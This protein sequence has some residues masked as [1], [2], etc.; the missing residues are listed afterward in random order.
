[1]SVGGAVEEYKIVCEFM[2]DRAN[3]LAAT[4]QYVAFP[5]A[6]PR[7]PVS[8]EGASR[9]LHVFLTLLWLLSLGRGPLY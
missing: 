4:L 9:Y 8:T 3:A 1:M 7:S 5:T 6:S 2:R